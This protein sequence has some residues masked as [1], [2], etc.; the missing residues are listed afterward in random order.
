MYW[1]DKVRKN[2][3]DA[4]AFTSSRGVEPP[5]VCWAEFRTI[6]NITAVL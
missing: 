2:E 5:I 3:F 4:A 6:I 1:H